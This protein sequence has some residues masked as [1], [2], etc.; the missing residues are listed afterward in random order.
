MRTCSY[1]FFY[2]TAALFSCLSILFV[3]VPAAA[4]AAV[5]RIGIIT[6]LQ[7][8][9]DTAGHQLHAYTRTYLTELS[10][11]TSWSYTYL[12]DTR[13]NCLR[14]L[15]AG[16]LDFIFPVLDSPP[17]RP[18]LLIT[19][20]FIAYTPLAIFARSDHTSIDETDLHTLDGCKIG[21]LK[22]AESPALLQDF[23]SENHLT[24]EPC[25]FFT[26]DTLHQALQTGEVDAI[27]DNSAYLQSNEKRL[28]DLAI[29]PAQ[30]MTTKKK[31][32]LFEELSQAIRTSERTNPDLETW[33]E[34][35]FLNPAQYALT[36]YTA[37]EKDFIRSAPPLTVVCFADQPP[38]L[39]YDS[40]QQDATGIYPD[41]LRELGKESGLTF[42][43]LFVGSKEEAL[44]KLA[45][46][47]ADILFNI[48]NSE[49]ANQIFYFSNAFSYQNFSFISNRHHRMTEQE[50]LV[51]ALPENFPGT[52]AYITAQHPDWTILTKKHIWDCLT[53]VSE[54]KCDYALIPELYLLQSNIL[55]LFPQLIQL[56]DHSVTIPISLSISRKQP[57][58]LQSI[59][60]KSILHLKE[61]TLHSIIQKHTILPL[62]NLTL[63]NLLTHYP[64]QAAGILCILLILLFIAAAILYNNHLHKHQNLLLQQKNHELQQALDNL[65]NTS[66]ARDSYKYVAEID[67]LTGLMNKASL[68]A[69][70]RETFLS[71]IREG[72]IHAFFMI[73]L[74]HFKT[75]NDTYGH[76]YGDEILQSFAASL[77]EI[78]RTGDFVG[79]FGGD[80]FIVFLPNLKTAQPLLRIANQIRTAARELAIQNDHAAI[81]ASIGIAIA[82]EHGQTYEEIFQSADRAL[83]EVKAQGRDGY[84]FY[85]PEL[86]R[87]PK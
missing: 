77:Q 60:N 18:D 30:L 52:R 65:A 69:V 25:F 16:E 12:F 68:E 59:L 17:E 83:Y 44:Q 5:V 51:I 85:S 78:F 31:E 10:K 76:Q 75:T 40:A 26:E 1:K 48:Y 9:C 50:P 39:Q 73:D 20:G 41:V 63:P 54:G 64:L 35:T 57:V 22:D 47:E 62:R 19:R 71:P 14:R 6:D 34:H 42:Q 29:V 55:T 49:S 33:L 87:E 11:Q 36:V 53:L 74:D 61:D 86:G 80:E 37:A 72:Y 43:F 4:G 84:L 2:L 15:L 66:L 28:L 21:L 81:T 7:T 13:E 32:P 56:P 23:L 58:L 24:A 45:T 46:G 27:I 82:P 79:R 38:F 70:C 67:T 3:P 8:P